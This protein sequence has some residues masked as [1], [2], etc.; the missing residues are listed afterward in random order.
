MQ[1]G[2]ATHQKGRKLRRCFVQWP[3]RYHCVPREPS[4]S[5]LR[6]DR[7]QTFSHDPGDLD[8][9]FAFEYDYE[10]EGY[11]LSDNTFSAALTAGAVGQEDA[12]V[13][14]AI[15]ATGVVGKKGL[16]IE[17]QAKK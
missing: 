3:T 1:R 14:S 11:P 10:A 6:M 13:E 2:V 12:I 17:Q 8:E 4:H 5:P 7:V 16:T 15:S 9:V